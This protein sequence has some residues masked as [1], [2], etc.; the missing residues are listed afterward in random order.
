MKSRISVAAVLVVLG[1]SPYAVV[2]G[3]GASIDPYYS[4]N[5][6]L[7]E[8]GSAPG[9]PQPYGGLTLKAGDMNTLLIGGRANY[10][11]GKIYAV[12]VTRDA[13]KHI[14]GLTGTATVFADAYGVGGGI[15][16]GLAYG[17]GGV[18]FYANYLCWAADNHLGQIKPGS[19]GPDKLI[20]LSPLGISSSVGSINFPYP[21]FPGA[22][23]AKVLSYNASNWYDVTLS[24][25][26][27]GTYNIASVAPAINLVSGAD[28]EGVTFIPKGNALFPNDSVLVSKFDTGVVDA[29]EVNN[30]GDPVVSSGRHFINGLTHAEGAYTDPLT[31]DFLFSIWGTSS[32]KVFVVRGFTPLPEPSTL[33]LL[34]IGAL[35]LLAYA[36]RRRRQP[37]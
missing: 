8:L 32:D 9:V 2:Q 31:G 3:L 35:S 33:V 21:G 11:D 23:H 19:T 25:D 30:N 10:S 37:A 16:G 6:T 18:L 28:L 15:D 29:Y 36:W 22:G 7:M 14:T 1:G 13:E 4:A 27:N 20:D 24:A 26:G 17:P 5:Y 34:A 12:T